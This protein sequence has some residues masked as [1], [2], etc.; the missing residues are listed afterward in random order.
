MPSSDSSGSAATDEET[1]C[2]EHWTSIM[3]ALRKQ[4]AAKARNIGATEGPPADDE[5]G[6]PLAHDETRGPLAADD[7]A[8]L[9]AIAGERVLEAHGLSTLAAVVKKGVLVAFEI[10]C[11]CH[12]NHNDRPGTICKK[13]LPLGKP[14]MSHAEAQLRLKRWYVAGANETFDPRTARTSHVNFGG[15]SLCL[16]DSGA[17]GWCDISEEDLNEMARRVGLSASGRGTG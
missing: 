6:G 9:R 11:R 16:L 1:S 7:I 8:A 12:N 4:A 2:D 5:T 17:T 10:R 3:A 13:H 14:P 15:P